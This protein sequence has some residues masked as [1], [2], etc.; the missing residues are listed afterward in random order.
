MSS[1]AEI[2]VSPPFVA[3]QAGGPGADDGVSVAEAGK[4]VTFRK[5]G[6]LVQRPERVEGAHVGVGTQQRAQKRCGG[7]VATFAEQAYRRVPVPLVGMREKSDEFRGVLGGEIHVP[8]QRGVF[9]ADAVDSTGRG[10]DLVLV[11]LAVGDVEVVHVGHD[12]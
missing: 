11:M 1:R 9:R 6:G 12:E 2:P 3:Q 4:G 5:S 7:G 10:I 8:L